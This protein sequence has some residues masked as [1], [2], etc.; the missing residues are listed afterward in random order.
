MIRQ[1][2]R[3]RIVSFKANGFDVYLGLDAASNESLVLHHRRKHPDCLWFHAVGGVGP[4]LVMCVDGVEPD[5][6]SINAVV[7]MA[8]ERSHSKSN[9]P[10]TLVRMARLKNVSKP[11]SGREGSWMASPS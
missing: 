8:A 11:L 2:P 1:Q 5:E 10:V 3:E 4:H 7:F 6:E 9:L